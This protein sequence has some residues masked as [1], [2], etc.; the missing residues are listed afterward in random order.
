MSRFRVSAL[1]LSLALVATVASSS[2]PDPQQVL[3]GAE[4]NRLRR[5]DIDTLEPGPPLEDIHVENESGDPTNG[6]DVNGMICRIPDGSGRFVMGED[7]GQPNPPA[8]WGVFSPDGTQV[9]KLTA[10]YNVS[11]PE[12]FGCAFDAAGRLFTTEVGSQGFD[13][14]DGQ[15]IMWF[16]PYDRFPGPPGAYPATNDPSDH[17][18]KIAANISTALGI[19]IDAGGN[20][21]VA[22]SGGHAVLKYAPPFPTGPDAAGGCGLTDPLGSPLADTVN[23]TTHIPS[24]S[25]NGMDTFTGLALAPNGNLYVA[26]ILSG[27]IA[28]FDPSG[29]FVRFI[30]DNTDFTFPF[31]HG[32]PQGLAVGADGTLYYAD[33]DLVGTFPN[34]GPGSNGSFRRITFDSGGNPNTPEIIKQG[35]SFPDGVSV[36]SGD[37]EAPR[38]RTYGGGLERTFFYSD[39]S[40]LG[41]GN[42]DD[43]AVRWDYVANGAITATPTVAEVKVPGVGRVPVA[44]VLSWDGDVYAVRVDSGTLLW[45]F[46]TEP[47]PG[48]TFGTVA[49][50]DV[51]NIDGTD[52]V[53]IGAGEI[54]YALDA[55]TGSEIWRFTAGTGCVDS[56]GIPPGLCDEN[57]ERNEIESS[58]AVAD[59]RLFFGMDV[60]DRD[61]GKG[62]FYAIDARDGR[63]EWFFDLESGETCVPFAADDIRQYDPYH[64][65]A[66]L[67]LPAGFLATRPGCDHP[68]TPNGCGNVWSS[69]A[70]DLDR[71]ALFVASSNCDT[72]SDAGTNKPDP[73]M[74][75][76]DEALFAL[77]FDG[78]P[79]WRWRPREVDNDD[80]AFGA[81]PN[82]FTIDFG[83]APREVVGIGNKD[84]TYYVIDRDGTNEVN[85]FSWDDPDPLDVAQVPYWTR[86]VVAGGD[87]GGILA[88]ASVDEAD[89]RIYLSTAAGLSSVHQPP[90]GPQKPTH[91]AL[92]MD[93]G[94][95]VCENG[96]GE[97]FGSFGPTTAIPDVAFFGNV[98]VAVLNARNTSTGAVILQLFLGNFFALASGA[99]PYGGS[100]LHGEGIGPGSTASDPSRLLALCA[101]G[102]GVCGVCGNGV[103][104]GVEECDDSNAVSGDGCWATCETEEAWV[105]FGVAEG[106]TIDF[107]ID[108]V[109]LSVTTTAGESAEEVAAKIAA[110]INADAGLDALNTV[111][112]AFE[113]R[114]VTNGS[115]TSMIVNDPGISHGVPLPVPALGALGLAALA[116]GLFAAGA[117]LV[118][119]VRWSPS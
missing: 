102:S 13:G 80:L 8:G 63:M 59:G 28:E 27:K 60:N 118:A 57:G 85:G 70:L 76:W 101:T 88:A 87:I 100:L 43:L 66:E 112:T 52:T 81:P 45:S 53:F 38:W 16:P 32:T 84:G 18:C 69:P 91:Q 73:P 90:A 35:L 24:N 42:V 86:N 115:V 40:V 92:D 4:D 99:V 50:V 116:M 14:E 21:F 98:P 3:Y 5:F 41:P 10:T 22:A 7:T 75:P 33:L 58:V 103:L 74:P 95:I 106:G 104:E 82:L 36:L 17:F 93:E 51:T 108:G 72:D 25:G 23:R 114:V 83:G 97:V 62:G 96:T 61:V 89:R 68:R 12:P 6:R 31:T 54:L 2:P 49:S 56:M 20:V 67:D 46:T 109:A 26:A 94:T 77:G 39:E 111:A 105:L 119:W 29:T 113:H 1:S 34:I 71:E 110:A 117:I 30:L 78:F 37:L 19:A 48:A 15:L 47:Q 44:Y 79:L 64:S 11:N 107:V 9:G 65:E 55:A